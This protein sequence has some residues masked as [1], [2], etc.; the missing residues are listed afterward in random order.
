MTGTYVYRKI[1]STM[2]KEPF[3]QSVKR[4]LSLLEALAVHGEI[5][6]TQL[7]DRTGL[8]PSTAHRLLATLV[9]FGYAR[10]NPGTG[11]Y[12]MGFKALELASAVE[13]SMRGLKLAAWPYL[14]Q[15]RE[16]TGETT[17]LAILNGTSVVYVDQA[18]GR[19]ALRMFTQIGA[20][21]PAHATG[22]GKAMLASL[23]DNEFERLYPR[24]SLER[25][26]ARTITTTA[27]LRRELA[28]VRDRGFALDDEEYT[29]GV[30]CVAAP[31]PTVGGTRAAISV[32]GPTTR[33]S[34][35]DVQ[36][37]GRALAAHGSRIA[38]ARPGES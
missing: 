3:V 15:V 4:S 19:H 31:I 24:T 38:Q 17:N 16:A 30:S 9:E 21:V 25:F 14:E 23:R 32:S 35:N 2:R 11:R 29:E 8:K 18:E 22:A 7:A 28:R 5:G 34:R 13:T 33:V 36:K 26:T 6:L 10:Q 1:L 20:S 37:L 12:L 27:E